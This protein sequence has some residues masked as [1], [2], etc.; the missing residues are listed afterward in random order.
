MQGELKPKELI[1]ALARFNHYYKQDLEDR[2]RVT[3][4]PGDVRCW[5]GNDFFEEGFIAAW[6]IAHDNINSQDVKGEE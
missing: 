4:K 3:H 5:T 1:E 2:I 6:R